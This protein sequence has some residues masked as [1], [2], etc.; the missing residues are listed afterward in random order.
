MLL[1]PGKMP[2]SGEPGGCHTNTRSDVFL[3]DSAPFEHLCSRKGNGMVRVTLFALW[4]LLLSGFTG[5]S[6]STGLSSR[7]MG[8]IGGGVSFGIVETHRFHESEIGEPELALYLKTEEPFGCVNY[9]LDLDVEIEGQDLFV[10]LR[11]VIEPDVCLTAIGPAISYTRLPISEGEYTLH[12]SYSGERDSYQISISSQSVDISPANGEFTRRQEE[13]LWRY[14]DRS[15]ALVC[16]VEQSGEEACTSLKSLLLSEIDLSELWFSGEGRI[17]FPSQ[18]DEVG[19]E[20]RASYFQLAHDEDFSLVRQAF[21]SF[22]SPLPEV[23]AY[24]S[25]WRNELVF[26]WA[27]SHCS[28]SS[29]IP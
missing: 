4:A 26:S 23:A 15:F 10:T 19:H 12:F 6:D 11:G 3:P 21:C 13:R 29:A 2:T 8:K 1:F 20:W 5:C 14:P 9:S 27:P 16:D 25:S 7:E 28:T 17:P 24:L 18:A 22:V